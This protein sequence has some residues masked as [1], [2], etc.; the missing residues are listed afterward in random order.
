M[1][2]EIGYAIGISPGGER[3]ERVTNYLH[4]GSHYERNERPMLVEEDLD[5]MGDESEA[6]EYDAKDAEGE[7]WG[8]AVDLLVLHREKWSRGIPIDDDSGVVWTVWIWKVGVDEPGSAREGFAHF[9][10]TAAGNLDWKN[11]YEC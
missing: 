6:E 2:D 7:V 9:D 3:A 11:L 4:D 5:A 1:D 10:W 8:V